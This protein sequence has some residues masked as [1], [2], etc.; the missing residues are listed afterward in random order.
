M[1]F[2][3][4]R[5]QG[6]PEKAGPCCDCSVL[7][8]GDVGASGPVVVSDSEQSIRL[9]SN[10]QEYRSNQQLLITDDGR[11]A[12]WTD[13]KRGGAEVADGNADVVPRSPHGVWDRDSLLEC[14]CVLATQENFIAILTSVRSVLFRPEEY[15]LMVLLQFGIGRLPEPL[16]GG[17]PVIDDS[18]GKTWIW[19]FE[20]NAVS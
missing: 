13:C 3:C 10:R 14:C 20:S 17:C 5:H 4:R 8:F 9:F 19:A 15:R 11:R 18:S 7:N 1:S 12:S 16:G 6:N 2:V